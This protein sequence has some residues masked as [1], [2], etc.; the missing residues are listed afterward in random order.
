MELIEGRNAKEERRF[1]KNVRQIGEPSSGSRILIEDYVYTFLRQMAEADQT[2][3]KTAILLGEFGTSDIYIQGALDID[4]GQE[5]AGWFSHEHW[6]EIFQEAQTW[7]E[8]LEVVGWFMANPGFPPELT[9]ELR[10]LHLRNFSGEQY[11][12][13]QMDVIENEEIFYQYGKNGLAPLCG[14]YI[15]YEKNER[16]QAYMSQRRGGVGIEPEGILK[17][18]AAARFRNVM[19]EKKEQN[20]QKKTMA[21]LY[22]SCTFLVMVILVIGITMVNNYDRMTDME[23]AL[24]SISESLGESAAEETV[25]EDVEKEMPADIEQAVAEENQKAAE[26]TAGDPEDT[27]AR[28]EPQETVPEETVPEEQSE[29]VQEVMSQSVQEPERYEVQTGDTLLEICRTK[30]GTEDM[31]NEICELNELDDGDKIYVGQTLV[32]P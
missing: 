19:Q 31:L 7:F 1:P 15:Y 22:A 13:L 10:N 28:E 11:V 3:I 14:Y 17:D 8:G 12:F 2:C 27:A 25:S 21:F 30:Y 4:M 5:V 20:T 18:R 29:E 6:R 24:H 32:L 26:E 16:M 23:Q 9:E